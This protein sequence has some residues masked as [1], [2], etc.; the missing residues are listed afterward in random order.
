VRYSCDD[1]LTRTWFRTKT[2]VPLSNAQ[3]VLHLGNIRRL[4]DSLLP[5]LPELAALLDVVKNEPLISVAVE[6]ILY[7]ERHISGGVYVQGW[8]VN[9]LAVFVR[10]RGSKGGQAGEWVSVLLRELW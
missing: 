10:E 4:A 9:S 8:L 5:D 3:H 2:P 1:L 6:G 7:L